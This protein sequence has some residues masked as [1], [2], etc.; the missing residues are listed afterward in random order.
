MSSSEQVPSSSPA[1]GHAAGGRAS[2]VTKTTPGADKIEI[3]F[4]FGARG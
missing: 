1:V 4:V 2:H 3:H